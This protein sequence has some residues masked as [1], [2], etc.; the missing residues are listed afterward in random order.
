MDVR[1]PDGTIITNVPDNVTQS[2][3]LARYNRFAG[4]GP[5]ERTWGEAYEDIGA[6]AV[7]G[8]GSLVQLPSQLYGL[9]TGD[10]SDT[11]LMKA[12]REIKEKGEKFKSEALKERERERSKKIAEAEKQGIV[13]EFTT[14]IGET[15][16]DP[17]LLTSFL[18]EQAPQLLVPLGAA[19]ASKAAVLARQAQLGLAKE[20]AEEA[21]KRIATSAA[22]GAGAVQ[23]GADIA[24]QSYENIY[25]E[26]IRQGVIP[27]KAA[28]TALSQARAAGASAAVISLLAQRLPG[29]RTLEES[30]AGVPGVG[31]RLLGAGKGL[32][33]EAASEIAEE[34]GGKLTENIALRDIAPETDLLKG[35]GT[36]AGLAAIGGGTF[37]GVAGA[38]RRPGEKAEEVPAK[39]EPKLEVKTTAYRVMDVA[40]GEPITVQVTEDPNTGEVNAIGP[41]GESVDLT[42]LMTRGKTVEDAIKE[43]YSDEE[44]PTPSVVTAIPEEKLSAEEEI[45]EPEEK[46]I[47]EP[48]A[49]EVVTKTGESIS[50]DTTPS[51]EAFSE[52]VRQ[53]FGEPVSLIAK[54][55]NGNE[56]G[57]L[58]YMPDGGP[59][60]V[61]V[62]EEN[63]RQGIAT[64]LYNELESRGITIPEESR[65]YA[66]SE[67]AEKLR[68]AREAEPAA[69][70]IAEPTEEPAAEPIVEPSVEPEAK[71]DQPTFTISND[72]IDGYE[73]QSS[74]VPNGNDA[75]QYAVGQV[76][77][78]GPKAIFR[79]SAK[80]RG[81]YGGWRYENNLFNLKEVAP[82][83]KAEELQIS[84]EDQKR[85]ALNHLSSVLDKTVP[86]FR[87]RHPNGRVTRT[88]PKPLSSNQKSLIVRLFGDAIDLGFP[89]SLLYKVTAGGITGMNNSAAIAARDGWL[90]LGKDWKTLTDA[91][92]LSTLV[93]ELGHVVDYKSEQDRY[94]I[95]HSKEWETPHNELKA[96]YD[97]EP[98]AKNPLS[99]PFSKTFTKSIPDTRDESFPQAFALY[100]TDPVG[101]Q[102]NASSAYSSIQSI[103]ERIQNEPARTKAAGAPTAE[104]AG[105]EIRE[106][107]PGKGAEIQP[108]IGEVG[109]SVSRVERIQDRGVRLKPVQI[110]P[111]IGKKPKEILPKPSKE[112]GFVGQLAVDTIK[113]LGRE[114]KPDLTRAEKIKEIFVDD[115]GNTKLTKENAKVFTKRFIDKVETYAFSSDAGFNNAI[116]RI[117][118][119]T[120]MS[121]EEK[122]G[123]LLSISSSQ[124]VHADAIA[125]LFMRY[126][127]IKYNPKT[128]KYE[129]VDKDANLV[130][131]V[132]G[133]DTLMSNYDITKDNAER[134]AHTAFEAKRLKSLV[135]FND[136]ID[137][138]ISSTKSEIKKARDEGRLD[139]VASGQKQV[140]SLV[141][142]KKFIHM[143]DAE[144]EDGLKLFE[145]MPEL[146][147]IVDTWNAMRESAVK[148]LLDSG[149]WSQED[150]DTLLSNMDYVPFYREDQI[151]QNKGPKE[152]LNRLQVQAKEKRLKGSLL[153]VNDIFDNMARWTQYAVKR[154]V[155]N[156]LALAKI[157]A[158]VEFDLAKKVPEAGKNTVRVW[159]DGEAEYYVFDDP[160][161]MEAFAGLESVS[162]P[163][164]KFAAK[165]SNMLRQ[166]VVLYP[167][168]SVAQVPQ[169]AF[170][171]MFTSGLKPRFALSIPARAVKEFLT[172]LTKSSKTHQQ[173]ERIG[174]VGIRDFT[175]QIAR[176]DAEV[177]AGLKGQPGVWNK[178]KGFLEHFSMAS[179]NA[180]R[181]AVYEAA[182]AQAKSREKGGGSK[183]SSM[184][185]ALAYEKAFQIINFKSRGSSKML[186]MLGQVIP[187]FNAYLAAQHVAIK[188][189]S[190]VGISPGVRS[191]ALKTLGYT[192]AAV[193]TLSLIY[194]MAMDDDDDYVNKP[195]V[196]RDRLFIIPGVGMSIPIR[197]DI[198]SIPKI[199][200]EH[201]YMLMTDQGAADGRKFRDSMKAAL[202]NALFSPTPIPQVAKPI[203]EVGINYNFFQ[204]R[205]LIG[206]YQKGLD[207]E[208]QFND[209]TSELSKL[210]GQTGLI[211]PIAADHL[212]RGM[213]GS[214][215]GLV[216]YMTNPL[217]DSLQGVQRPEMSVRDLIA[218]LPGTSGFVSKENETGLKNDFYVLRDEVS[219]AVNTLNDIQKRSPEDIERFLSD[220]EKMARV[221]LQKDI[222][223]I[224]KDLTSI[225]QEI[226]R[227]TAAE[228]MSPSEKKKEIKELRDLENEFLKSIDIKELRRMGKL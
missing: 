220:E 196:M 135:K 199:L 76:E 160:M 147:G 140:R 96:W 127:G 80:E 72:G 90:L 11:G 208:R 61:F 166:S 60:D 121:N 195:S 54:D 227:I 31:G 40:T 138:Q 223:K 217:I 170:A 52:L 45:K 8:L 9:V 50:I 114:P 205:P 69:E 104:A 107:R 15:V 88:V 20:S 159:R 41:D 86:A 95:S 152:Y 201:L 51:P 83:V 180:V 187:F 12:G 189:L 149:L 154:S 117:V 142:K 186:S 222:N 209:S 158:A 94:S 157:D 13:K 172:T 218:T 164:W 109:P 122:F 215:G 183:V 124:S 58:T 133:I 97:R 130:N 173:L 212:I 27:T 168:F 24:A 165:I 179:D 7:S 132:K 203:V 214:V 155:M 184:D 143:T 219:R 129:A 204:G 115:Q 206:T 48:T 120:T 62:P 3:L 185:Q 178:T 210:F 169:D 119:D 39:E 19:Q 211:S 93:H 92:R 175:A 46:S 103:V 18:A 43:I 74:E 23:Q 146:N 101:L 176:N 49:K 100:F 161:F 70:Q 71:P 192:T 30:F 14:A 134:I 2:D 202:G 84:Q 191:E 99:Y 106:A 91:E 174:A 56:V 59:I 42:L 207:V 125:S 73:V 47:T 225:R 111:S 53:Q 110:F 181:Q 17:A 89:A 194:A 128:Y 85:D 16:T 6:S 144:I 167:L 226:S 29:A 57:R 37:G 26:L 190:G 171:A 188:T 228:N 66:L 105:V 63:R 216:L 145:M 108:G 4:V 65:G 38:L 224:T 123:L 87:A 28:E 102:T 136:D 78:G 198:F 193:M 139:K 25:K 131:L 21:A 197:Q 141:K 221:A 75:F 98:T 182:M 163:T 177:T 113:R 22:V 34:S 126:G 5:K 68:K 162:I 118:M 10:F 112:S 81:T 1:M 55:N 156:R 44:A 116:R 32:A 79:R 148:E 35:V 33:G 137:R 150:A 36:A 64:A 67:E 200:T 153:P 213:F 77:P 151:E 82:E